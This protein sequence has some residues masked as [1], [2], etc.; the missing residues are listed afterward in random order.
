MNTEDCMGKL[1]MDI[2]AMG[3]VRGLR[4]SKK[5]FQGKRVMNLE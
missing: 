4:D 5:P 3:S 1:K 2:Y